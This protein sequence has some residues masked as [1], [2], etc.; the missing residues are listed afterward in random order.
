L[1]KV[2]TPWQIMGPHLGVCYSIRPRLFQQ[3]EL[4]GPISPFDFL[5]F[6]WQPR[7]SVMFCL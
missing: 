5:R 4:I 3:T 1:N 7:R 6:N 2:N